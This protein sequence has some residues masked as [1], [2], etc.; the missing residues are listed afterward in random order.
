MHLERFVV[1]AY[2]KAVA[3]AGK[4]GAV[5]GE[6]DIRLVLANDEHGVER[7]GDFGRV[8][9]IKCAAFVCDGGV[10]DSLGGGL[11]LASEVG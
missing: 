9:D 1:L 2:N 8:K 7:I 4:I 11:Y 6:V 5:R 10:V 3:D